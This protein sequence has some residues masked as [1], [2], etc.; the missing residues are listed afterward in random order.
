MLKRGTDGQ[1]ARLMFEMLQQ[2]LTVQFYSL[3]NFGQLIK[4]PQT[5]ITSAKKLFVDPDNQPITEEEFIKVY[6]RLHKYNALFK[7]VDDLN[8]PYK[9]LDDGKENEAIY[10]KRMA[11]SKKIRA[12]LPPEVEKLV[13]SLA[14]EDNV[15]EG[16]R[17]TYLELIKDK[18]TVNNVHDLSTII[19][20]YDIQEPLATLLAEKTV[21]NGEITLYTF[22]EVFAVLTQYNQTKRRNE[23]LFSLYAQPQKNGQ[24]IK[25]YFLNRWS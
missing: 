17:L 12:A 15:I 5:D 23:L 8:K 9:G 14:L 2:N 7:W 19:R 3:A 11:A 21:K 4:V 24:I 10:N 16:F 13:S 1:K 20:Q 25:M 18:P 6:L 22:I